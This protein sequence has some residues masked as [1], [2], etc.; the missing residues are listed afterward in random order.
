MCSAPSLIRSIA[1]T[2]GAASSSL[3][4]VCI[5][6]LRNVDRGTSKEGIRAGLE[7]VERLSKDIMK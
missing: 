2:L 3:T 4:F 6:L 1:Y 7:P 5:V